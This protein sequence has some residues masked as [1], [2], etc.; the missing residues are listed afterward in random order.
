M[1]RSASSPCGSPRRCCIACRG[2]IARTALA[3]LAAQLPWR[4]RRY[5]LLPMCMML[6]AL[7]A[8]LTL[9]WRAD[10][11]TLV[12]FEIILLLLGLGFGPMPSVT[13]LALQN[14]VVPHQLGI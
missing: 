7:A 1:F 11:M 2:T 6:I 4:V 12:Q 13:A 14:A 9:G 8:V 5:K 10:R 3:G